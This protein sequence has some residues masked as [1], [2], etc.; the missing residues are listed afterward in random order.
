MHHMRKP[1]DGHVFFYLDRTNLADFADVV[2]AKIHQHIVFRQLFFVVQQ[3]LLQRFVLFLG[4]A[5]RSG[6]RQREGVQHAVFQLG[7]RFR[8]SARDLH[9]VA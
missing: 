5:A 3:L 4:F 1:L 8:R 6:S 9:I 2:A 7:E